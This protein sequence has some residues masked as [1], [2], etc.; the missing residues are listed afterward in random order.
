MRD[1]PDVYCLTIEVEGEQENLSHSFSIRN[2][3]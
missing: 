3:V 1:L 2:V